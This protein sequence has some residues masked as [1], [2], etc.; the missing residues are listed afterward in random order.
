[1]LETMIL[2]QSELLENLG[3][4]SKAIFLFVIGFGL[5]IFVHEL[6]HFVMAR[7]VGI[8]VEVFAIGFG[9][10]LFGIKR[11]A[12]D[13]C[14]RAIPFGGY[15]KM[16]GQEDTALDQERIMATR[17]DPE[18]FLAKTPGQRMLVVSGGVVMNVVFAAIAFMIVFMQGLERS[19]PVAGEVMAGSPAE[20]A[21]IKPGDVF[22]R[23]NGRR[24]LHF[25]RIMA[26]IMLSDP[27]KPLD[28]E[29][30]RDGKIV[31]T[32]VMPRWNQEEERRLI[33]VGEPM[34]L[35]VRYAGLSAQGGEELKP[36]DVIVK[37][38]S[39]R[40]ETFADVVQALIDAKGKPVELLVSRKLKDRE[41]K[42]QKEEQ[43]EEKEIHVKVYKRA[44]LVFK[45]DIT[46]SSGKARLDSILGM[47]PRCRFIAAPGSDEYDPNSKLAQSGDIIIRVA[48]IINPTKSEVRQYLDQLRGKQATL[49]VLRKGKKRQVTLNVP[50]NEKHLKTLIDYDLGVDD[51][52]PLVAGIVP[53]SVAHKANI[54]RGA[55]ITTC[56]GRTIT[57]W[58]EVIDALQVHPGKEVEIGFTLGAKHS[59]A[60]IKMPAD[61]NWANDNFTYAIDMIT[62]KNTTIIRGKYPHQAIA[63]GIRETWHIIEM[64]YL[65]IQRVMISRTVS[66]R[67]VGGPV[68]IIQF[69]KRAAEQGIH[70]L[71]YFLALISANLAVVNFLPLPVLDGGL[72]LILLLEKI[73]GRPLSPRSAMI[74]QSLGLAMIVALMV[75]VTYQ[76]IRR[77]VTGEL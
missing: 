49:E 23:I 73:R 9:P 54:P 27:A 12:T 15:V 17:H 70:T 2:A 74:W 22:L 48:N 50:R 41:K 37:V 1:M 36:G 7:L 59:T 30:D 47:V 11:G 43:E 75:F 60:T 39:A 66:P 63:L 71:L 18:S 31:R 21:G 29:L 28:V 33:G 72:M 40:P 4:T 16:L 13:F 56:A 58:L 76:D 57:N 55:K 14:V 64:V 53:G 45:R 5:I 52:N 62:D 26:V 44:Y 32:T 77:I 20:K 61:P 42:G 24:V 68:F 3:A 25:Q 6:G 8:R 65:T 19:A 69:G 67:N 38:G 35:K 46:D 51:E 10:R 34:T